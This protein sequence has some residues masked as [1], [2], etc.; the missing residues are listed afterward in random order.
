MKQLIEYI[1][2]KI[3]GKAKFDVVQEDNEDHI[4]FNIK[5]DPENIGMIIGKGGS[6]IKAIRNILKIRA[7][8]EKKSVSLDV[9]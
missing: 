1:L 3:L 8:L 6:V 5:T 2:K 4:S 9:S 7:T